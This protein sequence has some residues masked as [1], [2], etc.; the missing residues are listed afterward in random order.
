MLLVLTSRSCGFCD[1]AKRAVLDAK[2]YLESRISHSLMAEISFNVLEADSNHLPSWLNF[3]HY[4]Q[5]LLLPAESSSSGDSKILT[6][7]ISKSSIIKFLV[8]KLPQKLRLVLALE[9][10]GGSSEDAILSAWNV[11]QKKIDKLDELIKREK[12][13]SWKMKQN[14]KENQKLVE[15]L[16]R[17]HL[18]HELLIHPMYFGENLTDTIRQK[19]YSEVEGSCT[20]E[21]GFVIGVTSI[22]SIGDGEILSGRGFCLFP[23]KYAAI[24][25]RPFKGEVVDGVVTQVN[26][27]GLMVDVGPMACFISKHSIPSDMEFDPDSNPPCYKT[28]DE[29]TAIRQDDEIRLKIVG[30][31]VDVNEIFSIG[32]LM[33]DYLG[34]VD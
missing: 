27:V 16:E 10:K 33:D 28:K 26:K 9:L 7:K 19:L 14:W 13:E 4:P 5:V 29:D 25:F 6:G 12:Y 1:V 2:F 30:T 8:T 23:I 21:H 24:V 32:S 22:H 20:G 11:Q 34:R 31:R 3:K 15:E 17:S 18:E